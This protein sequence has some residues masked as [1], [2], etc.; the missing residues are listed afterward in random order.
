MRLR[1][2]LLRETLYR[3]FHNNGTAA[4][5]GLKVEQLVVAAQ[6]NQLGKTTF[7]HIVQLVLKL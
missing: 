3:A 5:D 7:L 2:F 6:N 1:G 4:R